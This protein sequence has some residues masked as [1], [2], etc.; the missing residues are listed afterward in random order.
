MIGN[1]SERNLQDKIRKSLDEEADNL[2][3]ATVRALR[4]MRMEALETLES[5]DITHE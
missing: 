5:K 2:D 4:S 1:E 3:R